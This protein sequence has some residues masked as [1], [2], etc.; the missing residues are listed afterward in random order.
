MNKLKFG[1][2]SRWKNKLANVPACSLGAL[3]GSPGVETCL[4]TDVSTY[5]G[6]LAELKTHSILLRVRKHNGLCSH[7]ASL[8]IPAELKLNDT[9]ASYP[10]NNAINVV[11]SYPRS[12]TTTTLASQ[13]CPR[14]ENILHH[15]API[16]ASQHEY[17]DQHHALHCLNAQWDQGPDLASGAWA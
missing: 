9:W 13:I 12:P 17:Q 6:R 10:A 16:S 4:R 2:H 3:K 15:A 14:K 11:E 5:L 8:R 7:R 1:K